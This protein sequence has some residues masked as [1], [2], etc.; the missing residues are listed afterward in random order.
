MPSTPT[1]NYLTLTLGNINGV[2]N[3][4]IYDSATKPTSTAVSALGTLVAQAPVATTSAITI[5]GGDFAANSLTVD[6]SNGNP[7]PGGTLGLTFDGNAFPAFSP[8][9]NGLGG[10]RIDHAARNLAHGPSGTTAGAW[11][12]EVNRPLSPNSG[13]FE[14]GSLFAIN[15]LD[16]GSAPILPPIIDTTPAN[17]VSYT[18]LGNNPTSPINLVKG[19]VI[20]GL[21]STQVSSSS[22]TSLFRSISS[23]RPASPPPT[24]TA[25][26]LWSS[27]STMAIRC[28][29]AA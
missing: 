18:V 28:P 17:N 24:P 4:E 11:T 2:S 9:G 5:N 7:I 23:T 13:F 21:Q 19:P 8:V 27:I 16:M 15:Y 29:P 20:N 25:T 3:V 10:E 26:T 22:S 12:A 1:P 14:L 6:F